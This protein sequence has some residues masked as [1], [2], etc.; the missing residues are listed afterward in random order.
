MSSPTSRT[1][2]MLRADGWY[3]QTVEKWNQFAHIR[4]DLFGCID[5]VAIKTGCKIL[6]I[7]ATSESNVN[8]RVY[9]SAACDTLA[10]WLA[11]GHAEFWVIGWGKRGNW[12]YPICLE[13]LHEDLFAAGDEINPL[14][15][16]SEF[17]I[18]DFQ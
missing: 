14:H 4:Q 13:I 18:E 17:E 1:L 6:G 3:A 12:Y 8:A 9:K 15:L 16:G 11:T 10:T 5:I 7:Q 2:Q